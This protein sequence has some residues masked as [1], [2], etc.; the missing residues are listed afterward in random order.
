MVCVVSCASFRPGGTPRFKSATIAKLVECEDT[1][2][3][4]RM[5]ELSCNN[6]VTATL[7]FT[8]GPRGSNWLRPSCN[9]GGCLIQR[10]GFAGRRP[11]IWFPALPCG[12]GFGRK[13]RSTARCLSSVCKG[14]QGH[15]PLSAALD[16]HD[17]SI[18]YASKTGEL[19]ATGLSADYQYPGWG[20]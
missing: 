20:R 15:A 13:Q 12:A 6:W 3:W 4:E 7:Q 5:K 1:I 8:D 18:Q 10:E 16:G 9:F 11:A 19:L 14:R 2:G 17:K